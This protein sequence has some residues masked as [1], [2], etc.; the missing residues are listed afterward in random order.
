MSRDSDRNT[1]QRIVDKLQTLTALRPTGLVAVESLID[2]LLAQRRRD[3][4]R[5]KSPERMRTLPPEQDAALDSLIDEFEKIGPLTP[6]RQPGA[7]HDSEQSA[8]SAA[9][10]NVGSASSIRTVRGRTAIASE[11]KSRARPQH[12]DAPDEGEEGEDEE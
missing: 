5:S 12:H 1:A 3:D 10:L 2:S 11:K 9:S 6:A 8:V 4:P 7:L